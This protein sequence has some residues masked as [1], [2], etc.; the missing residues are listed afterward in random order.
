MNDLQFFVYPDGKGNPTLLKFE[1]VEDVS[2]PFNQSYFIRIVCASYL[3]L[4]FVGGISCK[5]VFYFYLRSLD[6][7]RN[8]VNKLIWVDLTNS[9]VAG[10]FN[11]PVSALAM[12]L[13]MSLKSLFGDLF[14]LW[15]P[16]SGL[17]LLTGSSIWSCLIAVF[18]I[19]YIKK[20]NWVK[21]TVGENNLSVL[22]LIAGISLQ[23]LTTFLLF[24]FDDESVQT[25]LCSQLSLQDLEIWTLY[26]VL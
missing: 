18:R 5:S 2:F 19:L 16:L 12:L 21:Y 24:F 26:K 23:M 22:L 4:V 20:H 10:S 3:L 9:L 6:T 14:C 25:K 13:P 7:K 1:F 15:F 11:L 8:P 17:I